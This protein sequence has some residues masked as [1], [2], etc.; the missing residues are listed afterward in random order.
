MIE[1]G[2]LLG[3]VTDPETIMI[4]VVWW[5]D[6]FYFCENFSIFLEYPPKIL[7]GFTWK[8]QKSLQLVVIRF[9]LKYLFSTWFY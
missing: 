2:Y 6:V 7:G 5:Q 9:R 4:I 1:M 8:L 3:K